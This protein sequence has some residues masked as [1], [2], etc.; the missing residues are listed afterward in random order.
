M[1]TRSARR[2]TV[3]FCT[4]PGNTNDICVEDIYA[5]VA[6][7]SGL[8]IIKVSDPVLP[9]IVGSIATPGSC[10]A[11]DYSDGYAYLACSISGLRVI[12]LSN[13]TAPYEAG[14]CLTGSEATGVVAI[15]SIAY[16]ADLEDGLWIIENVAATAVP[17]TS[18]TPTCLLKAYPNPFNP[19][20]TIH[21][22]VNNPGDVVLTVN[23]LAGRRVAVLADDTFPTGVHRINWDGRD[24]AGRSLASGLYFVRLVAGQVQDTQRLVLIR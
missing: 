22:T 9:T 12:D 1:V 7:T 23:D 19:L 14:Y 11:V 20:T 3:G 18:P 10:K 15:G 16:V 2:V 4:T 21:F 24:T 13:P 8:S 6:R 17:D 5:Y